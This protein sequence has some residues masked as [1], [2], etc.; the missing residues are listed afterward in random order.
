MLCNHQLA[1]IPVNDIVE[2]VSREHIQQLQNAIRSVPDAVE[3]VAWN[4]DRFARRNLLNLTVDREHSDAL[5]DVIKL[6][7]LVTMFKTAFARSKLGNSGGR[8]SA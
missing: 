6:R 2:A 5:K 1:L 3:A 7:L 4:V 8:S